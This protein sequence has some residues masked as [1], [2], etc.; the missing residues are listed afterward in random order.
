MQKKF[1]HISEIE[2]DL[3]EGLTLGVARITPVDKGWVVKLKG[4]GNFEG[5]EGMMKALAIA[6]DTTEFVSGYK[7][8]EVELWDVVF[9]IEDEQEATTCGNVNGQMTI[10]NIE[11]QELKW[12]N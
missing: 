5:Q 9:I 7:D 10:Y 4:A 6:K 3:A 11:T 8:G 2:F 1:L 12:L